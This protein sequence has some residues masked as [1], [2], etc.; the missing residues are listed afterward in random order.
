VGVSNQSGIARGIVEEEFVKKV[1]DIFLREH[2][3]DAFYYCPH[4]P[5]ERCS[6][7]KPEPGLLVDARNDLGVDFKRSFVVGDKES[8]VLLARTVGAIGILITDDKA[9]SLPE[10]VFRAGTLGQAVDLILDLAAGK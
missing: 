5:E 3:F 7:R 6:C 4:H 1:N 2:G 10:G 9:A 8:D